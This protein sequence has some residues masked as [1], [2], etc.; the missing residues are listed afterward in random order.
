LHGNAAVS[1]EMAV[2]EAKAHGLIQNR[3]QVVADCQAALVTVMHPVQRSRLLRLIAD[4]SLV[5]LEADI[6]PLLHAMTAD[7]RAASIRALGRLGVK[8]AEKAMR[9]LLYDSVQEVRKAAEAALRNLN[10][11]EP[12]A[13]RAMPVVA[14]DGTRS[15]IVEKERQT[16]QAADGDSGW[17]SRLRSIIDA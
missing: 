17:K 2:A 6:L 14:A 11:K 3:A 10:D 8:S 4:L 16:Q 13:Q 5:Q 7:E 12:R 1:A 9:S 15:W